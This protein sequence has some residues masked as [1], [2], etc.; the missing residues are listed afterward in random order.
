MHL[1]VRPSTLITLTSLTGTFEESMANIL[2]L[3]GGSVEV[4]ILSFC[5]CGGLWD[6]LN[7]A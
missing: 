5:C 3:C 6:G 2:V 1:P 7:Y 4:K